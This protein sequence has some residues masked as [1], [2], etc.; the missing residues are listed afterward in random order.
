VVAEQDTRLAHFVA[1]AYNKGGH[2]ASTEF[3]YATP[4]DH[5]IPLEILKEY[6]AVPPL[7]ETT[8][9]TTLADT[10][11]GLTASMPAG[12]R[13]TMWSQSFELNSQLMQRMSYDFFRVAPSVPGSAPSISFQAFYVPALRAMQKKGRNELGPD[14]AQGPLFHAPFYVSWMNAKDDKEV[15]RAAK[16]YMKKSV[17]MAKELGMENGY[18]YMPYN[19]PYR[20]VV[21]GYGVANVERLTGIATKYEPRGVEEV[22]AWWIQA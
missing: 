6:L 5:A 15:M 21:E 11:Y 4:V 12:F 19:S 20:A 8:Q 22:A 9:D 18:M 17:A 7:Q 2:L 13:T 10:T 14:P 3:E 1:V 16:E